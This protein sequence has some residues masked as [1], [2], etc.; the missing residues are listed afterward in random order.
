MEIENKI[1]TTVHQDINGEWVD[2]IGCYTDE[3]FTVRNCIVDLSNCDKDKTDEAFSF[4]WGASGLVENC[5]FIGTPKLILLAS[6]DEESKPFEYGKTTTFRNCIFSDFCR[7]GP[8]AQNGMRVVLENC[9]IYNWGQSKDRFSV[10]SFA[11]WAHGDGSSIKAVNCIFKQTRFWAGNF[12]QD[13]I[14]H[15]GQ[16]VNDSGLFKGVFS[17]AAWQP[18]VCKALVATDGGSVAAENCYKNHWWIDIENCD[19]YMSEQEAA[20]LENK[21]WQMRANIYR[22]AKESAPIAIYGK[23]QHT[24]V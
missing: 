9:L 16:A 13:F 19:G 4:T 18:G 22:V 21:L 24:A 12:W 14:G 7:R 10:R 20:T 5:V 15:L 6:G 2:G 1:V 8:E 23:Q 17:K 3:Q 11:S